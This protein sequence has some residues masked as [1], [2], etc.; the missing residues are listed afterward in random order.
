MSETQ[1][2]IAII[3]DELVAG[4]GDPKGLGWLGRVMARTDAGVTTMAFP[5]AVPGE[6]TTEM[7]ARWEGEFARRASSD[8]DVD[9]R[10]V[11]GLGI[12]DI[13]AGLSVARSRL[14][15]ANIL[16]LADQH[17]VKTFVVGPPPTVP[18]LNE[19]V[20]ELSH[21]YADVADRRRVPYVDTYT[22]LVGH[23]QWYSDLA[24]NAGPYP[25]QAGYGLIAWL[26]L[27]SGWYSWLGLP[28][29]Q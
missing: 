12:A 13:T 25:A 19:H 3:G 15:L 16:D 18:E 5:L 20:Q 7:S 26:V 2:R 8:P 9:H 23:D 24:V 29:D 1:L 4:V 28:D 21:A 10:L 11:I 17:K 22:P 6:T 27:H 14:N